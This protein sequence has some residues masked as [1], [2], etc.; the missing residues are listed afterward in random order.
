[1]TRIFDFNVVLLIRLRLGTLII[2][3]SERALAS[4]S[5]TD[6]MPEF[7]VSNKVRESLAQTS[8]VVRNGGSGLPRSR[9]ER[10]Y[11]NERG[12]F[13]EFR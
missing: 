3:A 7:V 8:V 4:L 10:V 11:L 1:M 12:L 9:N 6:N 5:N 2:V 13:F